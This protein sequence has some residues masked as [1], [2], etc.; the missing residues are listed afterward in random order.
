MVTNALPL[1]ISSS[2][3]FLLDDAPFLA[4]VGRLCKNTGNIN[5]LHQM[6]K[7]L[8]LLILQSKEHT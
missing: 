5:M 6:V 8:Y 2:S 4:T 3:L 7:V 1:A